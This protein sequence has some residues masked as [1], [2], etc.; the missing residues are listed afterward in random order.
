MWRADPLEKTLMQGK[1]EGRRRG[2]QKMRWLDGIN[3][4]MDMSLSKLQETVKD[5]EAWGAT[6]HGVAKSQT[7]LSDWTTTILTWTLQP[8]K[9][10]LLL[11]AHSWDA[12]DRCFLKA[13]DAAAAPPLRR[14]HWSA[15]EPRLAG[16]GCIYISMPLHLLFLPHGLPFP[17]SPSHSV[18]PSAV[19]LSPILQALCHHRTL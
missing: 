10:C 5:R 12:E 6:V 19:K 9:D 17:D 13:S 8:H 2:W 4:S 3:D 7:W 16:Q 14:A 18:L 15:P 11:R 1:T